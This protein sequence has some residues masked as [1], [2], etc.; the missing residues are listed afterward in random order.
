MIMLT[1]HIPIRIGNPYVRVEV[2]RKVEVQVEA[3]SFE[4]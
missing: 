3:R 4:V 1:I 2:G